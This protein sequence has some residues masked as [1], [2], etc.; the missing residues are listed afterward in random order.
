MLRVSGSSTCPLEELDRSR[1][2]I[3]F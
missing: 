3:R 2:E 1:D